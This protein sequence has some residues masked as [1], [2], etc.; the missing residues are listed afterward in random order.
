MSTER[1]GTPSGLE[2]DGDLDGVTAVLSRTVEAVRAAPGLIVLYVF[3]APLS[4]VPIVGGL[5]TTVGQGLGIILVSEPLDTR[6]TAM[7]NSFGVRLVLL[8]VSLLVVGIAILVGLLFF[9]LPGLYLWARF[10]LAPPAVMLDDRGP[11][12]ALG[13]SWARTEGDTLTVF[14]VAAS[15]LVLGVGVGG[16]TLLTQ[17][18]GVDPA[19]ARI[20]A[21][22]AL[23]S[24]VLS[25]F[26]GG[27]LTVAASTVMYL[28]TRR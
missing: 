17:S 19:V 25:T 10:Y 7:E 9:V 3:V 14:G 13:E 20:T 6:G 15:I 5:L 1:A 11:I 18:G 27:V 24:R 23:I 16:A 26:V 4:L 22:E 8:F 21:G 2:S 28:R 12:E